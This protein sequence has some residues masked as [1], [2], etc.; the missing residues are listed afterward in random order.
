MPFYY[1]VSPGTNLTTNATAN[2]ETDHL[3][4]L[5]VANQRP[6]LV[7]AIALIGKSAGATS[8]SGIA[9]HV[10]RFG[11]PSTGG[12]AITPT[13]R[14]AVAP[15]AATTAFTAPTV[16][17]TPS[18]QL[19]IGCSIGGPGAWVAQ[20]PEAAVILEPN[21]GANGNVDFLSISGTAS[22]PFELSVDF[23]EGL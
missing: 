2:T 13:P 16:G 11:T 19:T 18:I 5:T 8:L 4:F 23:S 1:N 15:A 6:C 9:L 22:L 3:R 10:K 14:A 17:S 21:G 12:T 20:E 7:N